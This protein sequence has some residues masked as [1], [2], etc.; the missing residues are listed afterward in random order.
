MEKIEAIAL[1]GKIKYSYNDPEQA[2]IDHEGVKEGDEFE[3]VSSDGT[4]FREGQR[5]DFVAFSSFVGEHSSNEKRNS[6][7]IRRI[8]G[9]KKG[10]NSVCYDLEKEDSQFIQDLSDEEIKSLPLARR[11]FRCKNEGDDSKRYEV[12]NLEGTIQYFP[13]RF[14]DI[15]GKFRR[16]NSI[17]SRNIKK[18]WIY[19]D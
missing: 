11:L 19:F 15:S 5:I 8:Y 13:E 3:V 9:V 18:S 1:R 4:P 7:R 2:L 14:F 17:F 6:S 16:N 10:L 12:R